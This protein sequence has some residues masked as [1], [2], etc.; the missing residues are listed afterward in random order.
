MLSLIKAKAPLR[1]IQMEKMVV[2]STLDS[3]IMMNDSTADV[4]A[5]F[6]RKLVAKYNYDSNEEYI[7]YYVYSLL[8]VICFQCGFFSWDEIRK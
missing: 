4:S 3:T 1:V 2:R 7:P 8:E 5:D 6:K